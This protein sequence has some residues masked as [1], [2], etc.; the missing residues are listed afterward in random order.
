MRGTFEL[1]G[2]RDFL[3]GALLALSPTHGARQGAGA[4]AAPMEFLVTTPSQVPGEA[5]A[6][7]PALP[8]A[9]CHLGHLGQLGHL[10]QRDLLAGGLVSMWPQGLN[11]RRCPQGTG[12][13]VCGH[14]CC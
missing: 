5:G 6:G 14:L 2:Q 1:P 9:G 12:G 10:S 3:P 7:A 8:Q 13:N 11:L 4:P